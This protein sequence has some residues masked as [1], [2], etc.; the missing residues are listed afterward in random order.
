MFSPCRLMSIWN[1]LLTR[2]TVLNRTFQSNQI[3]NFFKF[4]RTCLDIWIKTISFNFF[5]QTYEFRMKSVSGCSH[6]LFR[7]AA[8]Q[9]FKPLEPENLYKLVWSQRPLMSLNLHQ[10]HFLDSKLALHPR[11]SSDRCGFARKKTST[12]I[13]ILMYEVQHIHVVA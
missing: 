13:F 10:L 1:K 6:K 12:M 2:A 3:F 7:L 11:T 5:S 4:E 8:R 9:L